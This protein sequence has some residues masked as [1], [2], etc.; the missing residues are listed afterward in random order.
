L[1]DL[2]LDVR[3][4]EIVGLAGQSG[5]G[6]S[7]LGLAIMGL[8]PR[9]TL[10][11]G[12]VHFRGKDLLACSSSAM[13][14]VR[15]KQ[16]GMALQAASSALNPYLRLETQLRA[17]WKAH[18]TVSW[19]IGHERTL[20]ALAAMD[21][22][23]DAAFLRRYPREISVGQAQRVVLAMALLHRPA[24]LIA[25]EPTSALDLIAQAELLSLL[26]KVNS[27]FGTAMLYISHDLGTVSYLCHRVSILNGGTIVESGSPQQVFADPVTEF[28]R[29]LTAAH[30]ALSPPVSTVQSL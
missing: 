5:S 23:C 13:R 18:E 25:D 12:Y 14:R 8:L 16:I 4:G 22:R 17:V 26:K 29:N 11:R 3:E 20:E 10:V 2:R 27:E 28:T 9:R 6:K 21:L 19:A 1:N 30:R 24:L 15:G 7:T